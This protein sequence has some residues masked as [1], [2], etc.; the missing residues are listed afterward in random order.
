MKGHTTV[1]VVSRRP[2]IAPNYSLTAFN[3]ILKRDFMDMVIEKYCELGVT[4]IVPVI[5][6]RSIGVVNDST[7]ERYRNISVAAVLQ[8][9][10]EFV[11]SVTKPVKLEA[12]TESDGD[13][14]LFYERGDGKFPKIVHRKVRFIIGPEGGFAAGEVE[15]LESIGFQS[16]TPISSVLK[17]ETAAIVFAGLIRVML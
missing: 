2:L 8:S 15:Y 6:N 11:P 1:S 9:E 3:C 13:S 4:E 10:Q 12:I 16:V 7:L 17:A 5:S 14:L